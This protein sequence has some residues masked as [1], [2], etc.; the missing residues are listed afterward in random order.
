MKRGLCESFGRPAGRIHC[1]T[2]E[3]TPELSL[4]KFR[5]EWTTSGEGSPWILMSG[6]GVSQAYV[7]VHSRSDRAIHASTRPSQGR[8]ELVRTTMSWSMWLFA[9]TG[10]P[11]YE[12]PG[13]DR[14]RPKNGW[15]D[16]D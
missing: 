3:W 12:G 4:A 14:S 2:K 5:N 13:C 9:A 10:R 11:E 6:V 16:R 8:G 15:R 7:P 1:R